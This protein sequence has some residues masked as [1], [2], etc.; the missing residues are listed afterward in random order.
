MDDDDKKLLAGC[1]G[2]FFTFTQFLMTG[3]VFIHA[4]TH[5]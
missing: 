3:V 1:F 5:W 2:V 4:V